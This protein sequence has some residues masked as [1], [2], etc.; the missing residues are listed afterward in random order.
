MLFLEMVRVFPI[1]ISLKVFSIGSVI[2]LGLR[3]T[4]F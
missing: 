1:A 2:R 3:P 4:F